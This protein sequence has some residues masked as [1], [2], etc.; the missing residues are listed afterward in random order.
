VGE[1][2]ENEVSVEGVTDARPKAFEYPAI[3]ILPYERRRGG[4]NFD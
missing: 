2:P 3:N 1:N 4:R